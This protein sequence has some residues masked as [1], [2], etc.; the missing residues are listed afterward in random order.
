MLAQHTNFGSDSIARVNPS[1]VLGG[2]LH[3]TRHDL[4]SMLLL[5][6]INLSGMQYCKLDFFLNI[7]Q[8]LTNIVQKTVYSHYQ[9]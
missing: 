3:S 1:G 9:F 8:L 5:V 6:Q 4:G 7:G 2:L